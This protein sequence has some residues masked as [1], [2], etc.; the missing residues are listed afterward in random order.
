MS[1]DFNIDDLL[2]DG[3]QLETDDE[4]VKTLTIDIDDEGSIQFNRTFDDKNLVSY[5]NNDFG[6]ILYSVSNKDNYIKLNLM[7]L[8][9]DFFG[10]DGKKGTNSKKDSVPEKYRRIVSPI[11]QNRKASCKIILKRL[12]VESVLPRKGWKLRFSDADGTLSVGQKGSS[13]IL[14]CKKVKATKKGERKTLT[15]YDLATLI[16]EEDANISSILLKHNKYRNDPEFKEEVLR[17]ARS[18]RRDLDRVNM[19]DDLED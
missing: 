7:F 6:Y 8:S 4:P 11:N 2:E 12:G 17:I 10:W 18:T 16:V 3:F 13:V 15:K 14:D 19:L 1:E 9:S 5:L